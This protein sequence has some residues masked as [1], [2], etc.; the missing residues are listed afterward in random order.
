MKHAPDTFDLRAYGR[1][2]LAQL[3]LP[4]LSPGRAWRKLREWLAASPGLEQRLQ[5]TGY[6]GHGRTFTPLQVKLIVE[7]LG[8]P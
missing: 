4:H 6:D 1:T 3:Y 7:A 8:E 2:E 5:G